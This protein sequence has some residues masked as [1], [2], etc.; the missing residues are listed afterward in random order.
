MAAG[1]QNQNYRDSVHAQNLTAAVTNI[2]NE[3]NVISWVAPP[4][5]AV[6]R[7]RKKKI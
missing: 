4:Q 5:G 2:E 3:Y 6:H 1:G 7:T